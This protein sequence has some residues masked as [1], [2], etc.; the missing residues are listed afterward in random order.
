MELSSCKHP[1]NLVYRKQQSSLET[2]GRTVPTNKEP[3]KVLS[4]V[5]G[6]L[7]F[8]IVKVEFLEQTILICG[9]KMTRSFKSSFFCRSKIGLV[10][11]SFESLI[12]KG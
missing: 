9:L 12:D 3:A 5:N 6:N 8:V 7:S 4:H 11:N 2:S 10:G 1:I